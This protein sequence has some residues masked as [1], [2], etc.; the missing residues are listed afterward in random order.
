MEKASTVLPS[1]IAHSFYVTYAFLMTTAT[2][3]IIEA[4]RTNSAK[5][6]H[7]MNLETC[8]SVVATF[9]YGTFVSML[10]NPAVPIDYKKIN[11]M[12]YVDW[13]I[14]TPM[15]LLV[16]L[17]AFLHNNK[18]GAVSFASYIVVFILNFGMLG[19]GYMG[20]HQWLEKGMANFLGFSCFFLM[21]GYIFMKFVS[22]QY[23]FA[24]YVL[25]FSFLVLWGLYGVVYFMS[26]INKNIFYN[27]LDL[28][29]KCFVG[30]FL[31]AFYTNIFQF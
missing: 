13:C 12:R 20:D 29:A 1:E 14:T 10:N 16:L 23:N 30:L 9:F 11:D 17:I 2:I 19:F 25:F 26:E 4:L 3:T 28:F 5:V 8:I 27:V 21:F 31:W 18:L 15:M 24:N 22:P 6:R 7:V